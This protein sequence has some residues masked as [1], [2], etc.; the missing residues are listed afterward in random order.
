[1]TD[2]VP[3]TVAASPS[4]TPVAQPHPANP[5]PQADAQQV[6][7]DRLCEADRRR[8]ERH[9]RALESQWEQYQD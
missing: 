9:L 3:D 1:M 6:A 7:A 8:A 2:H 5:A 4:H